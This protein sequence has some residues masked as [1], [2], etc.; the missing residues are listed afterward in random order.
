[1]AASAEP[2]E[3]SAAS[4]YSAAWKSTRWFPV[5]EGQAAIE[6]LDGIRV[7]SFP[8]YQPWRAAEL[9]REA[10]ADV[11]HSCEPSTATWVAMQ[12]MPG[13][14]H[15]ITFRDPRSFDDWRK[16]LER[17]AISRLQVLSNYLYEANPIVSHAVRRAD[18]VY[19]LA[20]YLVPKIHRMYRLRKPPTFLP[21]PVRIPEKVTKADRPTVGYLARWDR[22]KRPELF[23]ALAEK[24]PDVHFIAGGHSRDEAWDRELR[25]R[26]GGQ[27]N[28]ELL[29]FVDQFDTALHTEIL[30]K[31]W[32]MVNTSTKEALPNAFLEAA[33]HRCAILAGL[34]PDGF[35]SRFG[36]YAPDFDVETGVRA[37]L[38][39]DTWRERGMQGYEYVRDTFATDRA[40]GLHLQAY[41]RA[42]AG[43]GALPPGAHGLSPELEARGWPRK[44][45]ASRS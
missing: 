17:P 2:R 43:D 16:E 19:S 25:S 13:R 27:P 12:A 44:A 41:E 42:L 39:G 45:G 20:K 30:S 36:Y 14:K 6:E 37:L 29:G 10:N 8:M 28:L 5:A 23:L 18:A 26:Y 38:E 32:V 1:M 33:A 24:F 4:W 31:C 40:M 7:L 22:V 34:D 21:T 11:Y 35:S 3:R 9:Y 15:V